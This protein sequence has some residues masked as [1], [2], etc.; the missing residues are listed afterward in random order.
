MRNLACNASGQTNRITF[1]RLS[2]LREKSREASIVLV[3]I[4][5]IF[6][7]CNFW[8]FFMTLLEHLVGAEYLIIQHKTFYTFSREATNFLAVVNSSINF[9]IYIIFGKDFRLVFV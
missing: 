3:V 6:L 5:L 1:F 7:L 8:G 9:V 2:E 4:V